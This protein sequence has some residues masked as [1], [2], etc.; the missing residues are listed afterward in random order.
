[1]K[2]N[3][4]NLCSLICT[5]FLILYALTLPAQ[6]CD[7]PTIILADDIESYLRDREARPEFDTTGCLERHDIK[8]PV[9][10]RMVDWMIAVLSIYHCDEQTFFIPVQIMDLYFKNCRRSLQVTVLHT[11]GVTSMFVA[12]KYEDI[13]PLRMKTIDEKIAQ[14]KIP[15]EDI[16]TRELEILEAL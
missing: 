14:R 6:T 5:F 16:K 13:Y 2:N 15:I 7:D 8:G 12:S 3:Y 4:Q 1:M 11:V 9:R 10:A